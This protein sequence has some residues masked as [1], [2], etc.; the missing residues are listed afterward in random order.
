VDLLR[1][2]LR[3]CVARLEEGGGLGEALLRGCLRFKLEM[4]VA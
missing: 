2:V 3:I 4:Q 1:V